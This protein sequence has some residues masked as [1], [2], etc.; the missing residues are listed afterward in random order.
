M[1]TIKTR[2]T[3]AEAAEYLKRE[4]GT[5]EFSV[6][7][8]VALAA[9]GKL[10]LCF[11]YKGELGLFKNE[12]EDAP[13]PAEL[14]QSIFG[15]ALKTVYF[16]GILRSLSRPAPDNEIT[17]L[18]GRTHKAHTLHPVRVVPV[19]V[20]ASDPPVELGEPEGHHWRR[21]HGSK[22]SWADAVLVTGIPVAEWMIEA[23]SLD[24]LATPFQ[25]AGATTGSPDI[26]R[27]HEGSGPFE[28]PRKETPE[29]RQARR[30]ARLR[31]LGG[32]MKQ[33]GTSW[34][35]IGSRGLLAR[36]VKE[37]KDSGSPMSDKTN[38][39]NDLIAATQRIQDGKTCSPMMG[40]HS[41]KQTRTALEKAWG[42]GRG[43]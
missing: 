38:V 21:V 19:G 32:H 31:S 16:N 22:S 23:E 25:S 39:R 27:Q 43:S 13:T 30:L 40:E 33:E 35:T 4:T 3:L 12:Q 42:N 7:D 1:G 5:P 10:S 2:Y 20:F 8:L 36:L 26:Q 34:R 17:G 14:A 29:Q 15:R 9:E 6:H 11:P 24:V 37:E 28:T 18:R 41:P